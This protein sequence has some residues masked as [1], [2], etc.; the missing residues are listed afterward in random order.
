MMVF[1]ANPKSLYQ[2]YP[3]TVAVVGA[4][5]GN[6]VNFMA[7]AWH[8][9]LS[10]SPPLFAVL[11]SPKRFTHSLIEQSG[12]FTASFLPYSHSRIVELLGRHSGKDLNKVEAFNLRLEEGHNV[13]CPYLKDAIAVY[14][15]QVVDAPTYGDHTL[16]A[17]KIVGVHYD[18]EAFDKEGRPVYQALL[19]LGKDAYTTNDPARVVTYDLKKLK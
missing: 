11:I 17:G 8:T 9:M 10:F 4:K 7:A 19:Y 14:E 1:E 13:K 16:F 2:E 18:P 6:T 12:E 15:C 5:L 3:S